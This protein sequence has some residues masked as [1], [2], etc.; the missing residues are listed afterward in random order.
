MAERRSA[1]GAA[2][3]LS[4]AFVS[5]FVPYPPIGGAFQRNYNLLRLIAREHDVHL[6]A[7]RHKKVVYASVSIEDALAALRPLCAS[8]E[9]VDLSHRTGPAALALGSARSMATGEALSVRL[10]R[11]DAL[12]SAIRGVVARVRPAVLQLDT[13]GLA[14]Y[15]DEAAGAATVVGHHN[16]ESAFLQRR[17]AFE[18]NPLA[19]VFFRHE[20]ARLADY[21]RA[22]CPR[23]DVNVMVSND[24]AAQLARETGGRVAVVSNGVDIEA[25][26]PVHRQ[27]G[28]RTLVFAGRQDQPANRDAIRHFARTAW[29]AIRAAVPDARLLVVGANPPADVQALASERAGIE[30]TGFVADVRPYFERAAAVVIPLRDGGGTRLKVIDAMALGMPVLSTTFGVSGLDLEPDRDVLLADDP[31][32]FAAQAARL[33]NDVDLQ[34][35]LGGRARAIAEARFG[36][37]RIA[38]DLSAVYLDAVRR[39][40]GASGEARS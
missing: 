5:H 2:S 31:A 32:A 15:L 13:I 19:R 40:Q 28:S 25:F 16:V 33:F 17:V 3:R 35:R 7:V 26:V 39:R 20:A 30:V 37:P 14:Q 4:V 8:L 12:R 29:P 9:L 6:V 10:Y 24:D 36:W 27:P 21:E 23:A 38:A 22:M 11:S 1:A 18:R 34:A